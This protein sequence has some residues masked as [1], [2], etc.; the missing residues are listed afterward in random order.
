MQN[1]LSWV[2]FDDYCVHVL[3]S[4]FTFHQKKLMKVLI[5]LSDWGKQGNILEE[6]YS[7]IISRNITIQLCMRSKAFQRNNVWYFQN[8]EVPF[9]LMARRLLFWNHYLS[10]LKKLFFCFST[11]VNIYSNVL[12]LFVIEFDVCDVSEND[13]ESSRKFVS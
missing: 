11:Y 10:C 4:F 5:L 8:N 7:K 13:E 6:K 12:N 2:S 3:Y 9:V 1:Q